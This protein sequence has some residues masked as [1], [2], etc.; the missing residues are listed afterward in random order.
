MLGG[1]SGGGVM[2]RNKQTHSLGMMLQLSTEYLTYWLADPAAPLNPGDPTGPEDLG[3]PVLTLNSGK[4]NPVQRVTPGLN[5]LTRAHLC[6]S[7]KIPR[8]VTRDDNR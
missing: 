2:S 8:T 7:E 3:N 1:Y 4:R 6:G 5:P